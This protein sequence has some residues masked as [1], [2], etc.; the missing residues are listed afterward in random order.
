[1]EKKNSVRVDPDDEV[2][3]ITYKI[4]GTDKRSNISYDKWRSVIAQEDAMLIVKKNIQNK[5]SAEVKI[6]ARNDISHIIEKWFKLLM[7]EYNIVRGHGMEIEE[8][9]VLFTYKCERN[10]KV[11]RDSLNR[12][13]TALKRSQQLN[14]ALRVL[15]LAPDQPQ[16]FPDAFKKC[17]E[18]V[19][20]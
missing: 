12:G 11:H 6:D 4:N 5:C 7:D 14:H 3:W 18:W 8:L 17:A 9:E 16:G 19:Y 20:N 1:M 2:K 10:E 15:L 13:A